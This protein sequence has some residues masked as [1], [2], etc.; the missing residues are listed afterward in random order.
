[1]TS[2]MYVAMA[3]L[4]ADAAGDDTIRVVLWHGAGDSFTAG[5][6]L[7]DF[8]NN[9]P[10]QG[11][12]P[13]SRLM[14]ALI[15]FDKPLVAA[16]QGV[17]IGGGSTMLLHCDFVY[18]AESTRFQLPF[19]DLALG[20]EFGSSYL[21]PLRAGYLRAAEAFFLA[22]PFDAARAVQMGLVTQVV[23]DEQLLTTARDTARRLSEKPAQAL[24]ACKRLLRQPLRDQVME[25]IKA[26][27]DNFGTRVVSPEAKEVF[28]AFLARASEATSFVNVL[29]PGALIMS[30]DKPIRRIAI[31]GTGVIG[32]SWAAYYLARGFDVVAT[33]PA[34]NA[35]A[36][37]R[38]YVDDAWPLLTTRRPVRTAHRE[39]V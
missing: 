18:A 21:M 8:L 13:Q 24:Q 14:A 3:E 9:P 29:L 39:I 38:K 16:V 28:A 34:P 22:Q 30:L 11:E 4:L 2:S 26:E 36:N 12:S 20:P 32:A 27:N 1:M 31:V 25:A 17:A 7:G 10:R 37:L 5:N 19:V 6:D 23:A 33:D 35:E 15:A